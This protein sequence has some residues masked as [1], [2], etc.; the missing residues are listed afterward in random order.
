MRT[1]ALAAL[2]V[3]FGAAPAA[4]AGPPV[5]VVRDVF[6]RGSV[7]SE[8]RAVN[9]ATLAPVRRAVALRGFLRGWTRSPAGGRLAIGVSDRGRLQIVDAKAARTTRLVRTGRQTAWWLLAWPR[10]RRL[11]ALGYGTGRSYPLIVVDPKRGRVLRSS[12]VAGFVCASARTRRGL[13]LLVAPPGRIADAT[14]VVIDGGGHQRRIALPGITAGLVPPPGSGRRDIARERTPGLAVRGGA[15]FIASATDARVVRVDLASGRSTSHS[16]SDARAAKG[17][18][19]TE[20]EIGFVGP[21]TLAIA[22]V[23]I[24]TAPNGGEVQ[25]PVGLRLVDTRTWDVRLAA[26]GAS[27]FTPLPGSGLALWPVDQPAR[28]LILLNSD[29]RRRATVLRRQR[30][31]QVQYAAH[32]AY[33]VATRPRHRTWVIDLRTGRIIRSLATAQPGVLLGSE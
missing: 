6:G 24:T 30:L 8:L 13:A 1:I 22:G 7:R 10:D 9:P 19:G 31:V 4:M 15:A 11:L 17:V 28:G 12:R 32:Y 27:A 5:A 25:H 2:A 16:F 18:E 29:G 20:R 14:L 33:A 26:P 23:D 21:H 3:S